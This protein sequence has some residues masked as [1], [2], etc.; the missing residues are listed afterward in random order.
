MARRWR[1]EECKEPWHT[2]RGY[3]GQCATCGNRTMEQIPEDEP[4]KE[5]DA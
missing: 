3:P 2:E 5:Q 1:C 4:A